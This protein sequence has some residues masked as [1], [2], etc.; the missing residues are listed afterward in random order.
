[1]PYD[2]IA[3]P[4]RSRKSSMMLPPAERV[5]RP[6]VKFIVFVFWL[7]AVAPIGVVWFTPL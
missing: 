5:V 7:Y 6:S 2:V 3:W 1:M 4:L